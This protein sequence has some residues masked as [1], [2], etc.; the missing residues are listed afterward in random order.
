MPAYQTNS[1]RTNVEWLTPPEMIAALGEFDLDPC[2][3]EV[4]PWSTAKQRYTR[5]DDGLAR[6]WFGRIWLNP[7]FGPHAPAWLARMRDHGNGVALVPARTETRMF[8]D[9]VWGHAAGVC[10]VKGR[11]RFHHPD[12]GRATTSIN[13]PICLIAYGEHNLAAL[14]RCGFG[15]VVTARREGAG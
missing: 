7:P 15:M 11:P 4:M 5:R 13:S 6:P 12:G 10:F 3:P 9:S 2:T 14:E 1:P 8:F